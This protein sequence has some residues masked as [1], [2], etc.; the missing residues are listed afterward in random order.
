M[1]HPFWDV[2]DG[3]I[4]DEGLRGRLGTKAVL[5]PKAGL[6]A[7]QKSELCMAKASRKTLLA[8]QRGWSRSG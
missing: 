8:L 6:L 7:S 2:R 3:D 1:T 5:R 4:P